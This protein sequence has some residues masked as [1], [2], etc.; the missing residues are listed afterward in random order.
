MSWSAVYEFAWYF[1]L[2]AFLGWCGEVCFAAAKE[3]KFINR[4]FLNGPLCPIYGFGAVLVVG[5]LTPIKDNVFLLFAGAVALTSA[6]EWL[7][8]FVLEKLFHQKWWDYSGMPLN[9]GG[10]ICPLFSLLW[11]LACLLIVDVAHPMIAA[12]VGRI[13]RTLGLVLLG[14]FAALA[15][16]DLC[17][18]VAAIAKLNKRLRQLDELAA[19]IRDVSGSLGENLAGAALAVAEKGGALKTGLE[20]RKAGREEEKAERRTVREAALKRRE[21]ALAELRAANEALL[22]TY[23]FGQKRLIKAFP[24]MRSTRHRE[25]LEQIKTRLSQKR[26]KKADEERS[27]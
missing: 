13:P 12:L 17:A 4:G 8:G 3:G 11:G 15:L 19:R 24:G 6:L 22:S 5:A 7:T 27:P 1:F 9:L 23:H 20:E 14:L 2:Y 18:T 26:D 25:A 16:A 21:A 10:Y